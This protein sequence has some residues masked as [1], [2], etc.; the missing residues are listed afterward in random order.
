M[1]RVE[2]CNNTLSF[3]ITGMDSVLAFRRSISI[4]LREILNIYRLPARLKPPL[5]RSPGTYIPGL[6]VAG[7]FRGQG[8][9]EFWNTRR[10]RKALVFEIN[11]G[12]FTRIVV[13]VKDPQAVQSRIYHQTH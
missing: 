8:R 4:P 6:L 13:D 10:S 7:T 11:D 9:T 2:C 12:E 5:F 3:K 1:T